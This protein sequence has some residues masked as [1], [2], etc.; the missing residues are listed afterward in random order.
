MKAQFQP[1]ETLHAR[2][3][4]LL[5]A[6]AFASEKH[7]TQRRKDSD[8][9]PYINHPIAVATVLAAEAGVMDETV[10]IAAILHDTVEDTEATPAELRER[11]GPAVC[12][13]GVNPD[14]DRVFDTALKTARDVLQLG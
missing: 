9:S 5:G 8:A 10:L 3:V 2:P 1:K 4:R 7:R 11:F 6:L 12:A 14:L 13:L